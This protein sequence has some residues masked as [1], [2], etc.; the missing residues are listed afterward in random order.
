MQ[1][2]PDLDMIVVGI[3]GG[4]LISG[5]SIAAKA[6]KPSVEVIGVE[7]VR[8]PSMYHAMKGT[9]PV[10]AASTI[11]EG[12]AVKEPGK[13]TREVVSKNVSEIILVDEGDIEEAIVM[14]LEIEKTVVEGAG[15][16][17]LAAVLK[18]RDR[19]RGRKVGLVL[20][21][22]NIDPLMLAEIVERGMVRAGRLARILV[23]VRDLPGSLARVTACVAEQNANIEQVHHQ[24]AFTTLAV[25]NAE[26]EMVL[27]TRNHEH[28]RQIVEAL[29]KDGFNARTHS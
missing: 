27:K 17:P 22:G 26:V 3:G 1:Q 11:A 21:G 8:F 5:I 25:Q 23:E 4:G 28:V 7:V 10:F 14:L 9:Q 24:R 20:G 16:A 6:M 19:F 18:N 13:I 12:I 2:Q 29:K 15:G